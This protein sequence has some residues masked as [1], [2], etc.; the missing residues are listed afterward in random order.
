MSIIS[1]NFQNN[2]QMLRYTLLSYDKLLYEHDWKSIEH[3]HP[4][5]EILIVTNGKG[6]FINNNKTISLK[7]GS[8]VITNPNIIHTEQSAVDLGSPLEYVVLSVS[9]IFFTDKQGK[10]CLESLVF[11]ADKY[12]QSIS[13]IFDRIDTEM[14]NKKIH[15]ESVI[16]NLL[17]ELLIYIVRT[18]E[19]NNFFSEQPNSYGKSSRFVPLIQQYLEYYYANNITLDDLAQKFFI[20]KYYLLKCFKKMTGTTP[21]LFLEQVRIKKA[22]TLLLTTTF[23]VTEIS[24]Q[25]GY[26]NSAY[27]SKKFKKITGITPSE[28]ARTHRTRGDP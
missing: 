13:S 21:I 3:S 2:K 14:M 26:A 12:W 27:F 28:F 6:T 16:Q 22:Q 1:V 20:N 19:L 10:G 23:S 17:S 15:W 8:I 24:Q 25:V 5:C 4:Y 9:G 18:M 7:R 11:N